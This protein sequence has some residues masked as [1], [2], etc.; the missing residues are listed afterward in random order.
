MTEVS[1]RNA[2]SL[3]AHQRVGFETLAEYRDAS[4]DWAVLALDLVLMVA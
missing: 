4:D 3:R 2:R 1:R